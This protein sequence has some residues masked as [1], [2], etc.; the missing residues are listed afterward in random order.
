MA[1]GDLYILLLSALLSHISLF[2]I[3]GGAAGMRFA[4]SAAPNGGAENSIDMLISRHS[5]SEEE[6]GRER[7]GPKVPKMIM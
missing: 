5:R 1:S 3:R 2:A 4:H 7:P 6:G